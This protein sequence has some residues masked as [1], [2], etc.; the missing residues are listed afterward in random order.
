MSCGG[1]RGQEIAVASGKIPVGQGLPRCSLCELLI[2]G[3]AGRQGLRQSGRVRRSFACQESAA[4]AAGRRAAFEADD[5]HQTGPHCAAPAR[6][7]IQA[8]HCFADADVPP[9][10]FDP[11]RA[12]KGKVGV[13]GS[14]K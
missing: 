2:W 7:E 10:S 3:I 8:A 11:A 6:T 4:G 9:P 13:S 14:I 5:R 1:A 12:T